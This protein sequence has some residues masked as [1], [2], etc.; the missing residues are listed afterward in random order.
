MGPF[1]RP[2]A[3]FLK[4]VAN[5]IRI[6]HQSHRYQQRLLPSHDV[7]GQH[8]I[9]MPENRAHDQIMQHDYRRMQIVVIVFIK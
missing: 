5:H 7:L 4:V 6:N 8:V 1:T 3:D 9:H 2:A